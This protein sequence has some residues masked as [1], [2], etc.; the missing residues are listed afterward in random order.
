MYKHTTVFPKTKAFGFPRRTHV[1]NL[2]HGRRYIH[3]AVDDE[4]AFWNLPTRSNCQIL[5][6]ASVDRG[7]KQLMGADVAVAN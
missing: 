4:D 2:T 3:M 6:E 5:K 1:C 7:L